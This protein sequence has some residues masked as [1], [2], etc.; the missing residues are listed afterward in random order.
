M[1]NGS[2]EDLH[3][4]YTNTLKQ[5]SPEL[6][7]DDEPEIEGSVSDVSST[8]DEELLSESP[9]PHSEESTQQLQGADSKP[10]VSENQQPPK[11][12]KKCD[13]LRY[14]A[15]RDR[16]RDDGDGQE[17]HKE[18]EAILSENGSVVGLSN[19]VKTNVERYQEESPKDPE[20]LESQVKK[21]GVRFDGAAVVNEYEKEE[22]EDEDGIQ[23]SNNDDSES[24]ILRSDRGSIIG[25]SNCVKQKTSKLQGMMQ[26]S[27]LPPR[28]KRL[29]EEE[30]PN[31]EEGKKGKIVIYMTS[32]AAI[33]DTYTNCNMVLEIF[34]NHN[35]VYK[36]KDIFLHPNYKKELKERMQLKKITVPQVFINGEYIGDEKIILEMNESSQ[37]S[38][39]IIGFEKTEEDADCA[40]CGAKGFIPCMWCKGSK[41]GW[42]TKFGDLECTVCNKNALQQCPDCSDIYKR[43]KK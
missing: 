35:V 13:F 36:T 24:G 27:K 16:E 2:V 28:I 39:K 12:M 25:F 37:L 20:V 11:N 18:G 22:E 7:Q 9:P 29:M 19:Q 21:T 38:A 30:M 23:G 31:K 32:L 4:G 43:K 8:A 33:R 34:H 1:Q 5:A 6:K 42:R 26:K 15:E 14:L 40:T 3:N 41:K 10:S 17:G